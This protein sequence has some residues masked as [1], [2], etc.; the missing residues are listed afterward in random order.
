M[1]EKE[2]KSKL[3][4]TKNDLDAITKKFGDLL[5][6]LPNKV[7]GLLP[8]AIDYKEWLDHA[9]PDQLSKFRLPALFP[10]TT[11]EKVRAIVAGIIVGY[12]HGFEKV[13]AAEDK[14]RV[15]SFHD[16]IILIRD[17]SH[18]HNYP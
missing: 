6:E 16:D 8:K 3:Q 7:I 12:M 5:G 18:T 1:E 2:K 9:Q 11:E 13:Q 15:D 14:R 17:I 10:A 4:K